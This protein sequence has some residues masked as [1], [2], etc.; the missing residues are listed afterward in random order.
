MAPDVC[1]GRSFDVPLSVLGE[2]GIML[3]GNS[4]SEALQPLRLCLV[5]DVTHALAN[6]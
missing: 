1:A 2:R 3:A 6:R 4:S 5:E